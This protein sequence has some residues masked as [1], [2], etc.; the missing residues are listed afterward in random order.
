[1]KK[2]NERNRVRFQFMEDSGNLT[3]VL[4]CDG[5]KSI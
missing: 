2:K 3:E 4:K 5:Q 1:M